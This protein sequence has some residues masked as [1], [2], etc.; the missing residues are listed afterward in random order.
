MKTIKRMTVVAAGAAILCATG[1]A[2]AGTASADDGKGPYATCDLSIW[3]VCTT[4]YYNSNLQG[5]H[6]SFFGSDEDFANDKFMSSGAGKGQGVK[7]NAASAHYWMRGGETGYRGVIYYNSNWKGPCDAIAENASA[8]RLH[9]T[10]NE[11][12]STTFGT[13]VFWDG[14]YLFN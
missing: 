8:N 3:D 12:A 9:N 10:Y 5:S 6:T 1:L 13:S 4:L 7:N 11:N 2:T 14:C